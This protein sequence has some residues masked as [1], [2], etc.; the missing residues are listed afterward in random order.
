[1]ADFFQN[2]VITTLHKLRE[3]PVEAL[4]A[5]LHEFSTVNPMALIL[6]SLYSELQGEALP[7]IVQHLKSAT[8]INDIVVGLDQANEQ[9]FQHA[10]EFF[11]ELPQ[12]VHILWNDGDNLL[13]LDKSAEE[14]TTTKEIVRMYKIQLKSI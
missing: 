10:K 5:E 11:A 9:Q 12:N 2:G 13:A 8:Y 6:P 1:M 7:S 3:R 4:E 14:A